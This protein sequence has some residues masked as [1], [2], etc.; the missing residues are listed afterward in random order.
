MNIFYEP[1]QKHIKGIKNE[2]YNVLC[3]IRG[4]FLNKEINNYS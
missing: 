2:G 1:K 3:Y 4:I